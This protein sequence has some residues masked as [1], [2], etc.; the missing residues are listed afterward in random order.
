MFSVYKDRSP[1]SPLSSGSS[2]SSSPSSSEPY[3]SR[4]STS[5]SSPSTPGRSDLS[6]QR[7]TELRERS[8]DSSIY[9]LRPRDR[10]QTL[11]RDEN[12][13]F[14]SSN[15][16]PQFYKSKLPFN[17]HFD[18]PHPIKPGRLEKWQIDILQN[19]FE[20]GIW[21][22]GDATIEALKR[23]LKD[24]FVGSF[25]MSRVPSANN[26]LSRTDKQIRDWFAHRR[27]RLRESGVSMERPTA[28]EDLTHAIEGLLLLG[29]D[30]DD[31]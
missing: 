6:Q 10:K 20:R 29:H 17:S 22:P 4:Y 7:Q 8:N 30:E 5:P 11:G 16:A 18:P 28:E 12:P 21:S 23:S 24:R 14:S 31:M 27:R 15:D 19:V 25:T 1:T 26:Y 13:S 3:S 2:S 9:S